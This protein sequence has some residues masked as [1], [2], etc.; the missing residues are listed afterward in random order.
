[1]ESKTA[2]NAIAEQDLTCARCN[3][4]IEEGCAYFETTQR[5]AYCSSACILWPESKNAKHTPGPWYAANMGNDSQGLV[6]DENT[7]TN[8]AV[9][10]D[11]RDARLIAAAPNLLAA[12]EEIERVAM[13]HACICGPEAPADH[14]GQCPRYYS[15]TA[16]MALSGLRS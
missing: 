8:I 9:T 10:Y 5:R 16:R 4:P 13:A 12:L 15:L 6:I 3:A 7:G 14:F 1:M 2:P 11:K